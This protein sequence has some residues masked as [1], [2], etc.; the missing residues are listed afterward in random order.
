MRFCRRAR[1]LRASA[2]LISIKADSSGVSSKNSA[3]VPTFHPLASNRSRFAF[4][5]IL[6][7][8]L[9]AIIVQPQT[10]LTVRDYLCGCSSSSFVKDFDDNNRVRLNA[11]DDAPVFVPI[12]Q[13]PVV[14]CRRMRRMNMSF[15]QPRSVKCSTILQLSSRLNVPPAQNLKAPPL[16]DIPY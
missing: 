3:T 16:I 1:S 8:L 14:I 11:V 12:T 15:L 5:I 9:L 4:F 6:A 10:P 7:L 13:E 2:S